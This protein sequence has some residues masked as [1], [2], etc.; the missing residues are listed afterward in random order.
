[1][2][3]KSMLER[4]KA[5]PVADWTIS[6]VQKLCDEN[7]LTLCKPKSGSHYMAS[8][9]LLQSG[10]SVPYA[11]PIKAVYIKRLVNMCETHIS[12]QIKKP[13]AEKEGI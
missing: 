8:S 9:P 10:Q 13:K 5:N 3:K 11:R 12:R 7:G 4:M 1:M 6:D 2:A